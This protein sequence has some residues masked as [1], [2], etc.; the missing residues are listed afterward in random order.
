[1]K[2][3]FSNN[4]KASTPN[5]TLASG[6]AVCEGYAGLFVALALAAGLEAVVVGGHGKGYSYSQPGP[7]QPLPRFNGNHAWSACKIDNGEWKLLDACW[8]AGHVSGANQPYTKQFNPSMFTMDNAEFGLRHFPED[9]SKWF[10]PVLTWEQY[11]LCDGVEESVKTY[12]GLEEHGIKKP[13]FQPQA[14]LVRRDPNLGP[15]VRFSFNKV[16]QH[17]TT[18]KA[19]FGQPYLLVLVYGG[20]QN[21]KKVPLNQDGFFWWLDVDRNALGPSGSPV[22]VLSISQFSG[23]DG[24][25]LTAQEFTAKIGRC[26]WGANGLAEWTVG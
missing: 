1:M 21:E 15:T 2:A 5:S 11:L 10:G 4:L 22:K 25:G 16:C 20:D 7:G 24:K 3:F 26:G 13:S 18:E 12:S 17:W 23:N 14:K 9:A 19:G 8:G 6:L